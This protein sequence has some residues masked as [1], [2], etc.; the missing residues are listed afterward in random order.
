MF[1][2]QSKKKKIVTQILENKITTDH[3]QDQYITTQEFN[4][5]TSEKFS[6]RLKQANLAS[7]NDIANF[8]KKTDFDKLKNVT[9]NKNELN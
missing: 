4:K 1:V 6:A 9:S 8:V 2:I 7:K 5:L 3:D